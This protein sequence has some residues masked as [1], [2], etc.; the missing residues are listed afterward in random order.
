MP[1]V[2][3]ARSACAIAGSAAS[4]ATFVALPT[5]P[6]T[7]LRA[8]VA[9][10]RAS[11]VRFSIS[12]RP[13]PSSDSRSPSTLS[14]CWRPR[15]TRSVTI[16]C[17]S[18]AVMRP[19]STASFTTSSMRSRVSI[20]RLSGRMT[21]RV[22]ASRTS[23]TDLPEKSN[24]SAAALAGAVAAEAALRPVPAALPARGRPLVERV[25]A[26]LRPPEREDVERRAVP[27][28]LDEREPD[29][30]DVLERELDDRLPE[31]DERDEPDRD[32]PDREPDDPDRDE[33]ER[34][35]D[36]R[37]PDDDER[38]PEPPERPPR[39]DPPPLPPVDS[40]MA[41]LLNPCTRHRKFALDYFM[42]TVEATQ[43][44]SESCRR[45]P[46]GLSTSRNSSGNWCG[47]T[48]M[49]SP[50]TSR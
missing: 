9:R 11:V 26:A 12:S 42:L 6:R 24:R 34:D 35:D 2:R 37:D 19:R 18:S 32:D 47:R 1:A 7:P 45:K 22:I 33:P 38:E 46:S 29:E 8:V 5:A 44:W 15:C 10:S 21:P 30:R 28:E 49:S 13:R 3:R 39:D 41:F 4:R 25:C 23:A 50:R 36:E 43:R 40:A 17:A 27:P 20:T 16:D 31:P 48:T 14:V